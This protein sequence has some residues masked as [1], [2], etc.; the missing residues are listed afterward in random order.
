MKIM[1]SAGEASGDIY[2]AYLAEKL[3]QLNPGVRLLGVGGPKM[4]EKGVEI[5]EDPTALSAVGFTEVL[6]NLSKHRAI[7]ARTARM[8]GEI[9]PD[10]LVLIDF[11]EFNMRLARRAA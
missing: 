7:F 6:A 10:C 4:K 5:L 2:G 8:L 1:I 3:I 11:P 9:T